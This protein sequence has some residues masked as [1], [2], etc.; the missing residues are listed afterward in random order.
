MVNCCRNPNLGLLTKVGACKGAGQ[1]GSPGVTFDVLGSAKE[2]EG[3]NLH[4]PKELPIRK[5]ES[6][7]IPKFSKGDCKGK[8]PMD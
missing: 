5:L 6:R 8:H 1:K 2:C 3:M 7:W 4:T